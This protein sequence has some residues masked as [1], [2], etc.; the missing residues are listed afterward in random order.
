[1]RDWKLKRKNKALRN[2]LIRVKNKQDLV[3]INLLKVR[4]SE[5]NEYLCKLK[6]KQSRSWFK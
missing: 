5:A 4:M 2:A 1:M 3:A 6:S